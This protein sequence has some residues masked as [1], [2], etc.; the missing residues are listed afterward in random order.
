MGTGT[1]VTVAA[2][3]PIGMAQS[4]AGEYLF[5]LF[6]VV[7][8]ALI[9]SWF[10]AA[11]FTPLLG[12]VLLSE[13]HRTRH[14][15]GRGMQAFRAIPPPLHAVA[16]GH[17]GARVRGVRA[18]HGGLAF[19]PRQF[20]PSADR[21]E[22]FVDMQLPQNASIAATEK[23]ISELERLLRA[24]PDIERWSTY[25]GQG[26]VRFYLPMLVQLPNNSLAQPWC[27]PRIWPRGSGCTPASSARSR[28][29]FQRR[30]GASTRSKWGCRWGGRCST[31]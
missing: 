16:P 13:S 7:A 2:F 23:A 19:V 20:F 27:S 22:L 10:V 4:S 28:S 15:P 17:G 25:I 14:E 3:L 21:P 30:S 18:C 29:S 31:A 26:A 6:A 24:D 5:S 1:L 9:A 12:V 11:I 8:V